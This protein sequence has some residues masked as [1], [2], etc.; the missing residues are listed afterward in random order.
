MSAK[1]MADPDPDSPK[2]STGEQSQDSDPNKSKQI[3]VDAYGFKANVR[4]V[5]APKT[6]KGWPKVWEDIKKSL[7]GIAS[8]VPGLIGDTLKSA[9]SFVRG[10]GNFPRSL[11][12]RVEHAHKKATDEE[13][14]AQQEISWGGTPKSLTTPKA[15][16]AIQTFQKR[17]AEQGFAARVLYYKGRVFVSVTR[18]GEEE[19]ATDVINEI[20]A[21]GK[22]SR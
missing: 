22:D 15:L 20:A 14:K 13:G 9:R 16:R 21:G 18:E 17:L 10:V 19:I 3:Q 2:D 5:R 6:P 12:R 1:K 7:Q 4:P 8:D 11:A